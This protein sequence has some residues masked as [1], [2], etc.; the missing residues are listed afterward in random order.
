MVLFGLGLLELS[1]W[2][3]FFIALTVAVTFDRRNVEEPKWVVA[4]AGLVIIAVWYWSGW[5]FFGPAHVDA[6]LNHGTVITPAQDRVVL[7]VVVRSWALWLPIAYYVAA[8]LVY[9][10]IEFGLEI[11]RSVR[12]FKTA[13]ESHVS[14]YEKVPLTRV[15]ENGEHEHVTETV[16]TF[17]GPKKVGQERRR[18]YSEVYNDVREKGAASGMFNAALN[19]SSSFVQSKNNDHKIIG[20]R[21]NKETKVD[22]EPYLHRAV[23]A[24]WVAAWTCLWPAYAVSL[25]FGDLLTE[26]FRIVSG[27]FAN[28]GGYVVRFS[29]RNVFKV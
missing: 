15:N 27:V 3:V 6:V 11:R 25:I 19:Y 28:L 2:A 5:T 17:N 10:C 14:Q 9:S 18:P 21:L 22:V 23:L 16:E 1:F 29:F 20:I 26:L 12:F 13:W 7:W 24:D 4:A 8:G